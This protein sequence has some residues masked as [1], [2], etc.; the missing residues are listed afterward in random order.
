MRGGTEYT[1]NSFWI[2]NPRVKTWYRK[3]E[4]GLQAAE[5][6]A[7]MASLQSSY[8]YPAQTLYQ[9]WILMLLNMDR[10]TLWGSAGGMVFENDKSWDARDRM[11]S[12]ESVNKQVH[13]GALSALIPEGEGAALFNPLNWERHDP[14]IL[15]LPAGKSLAGVVCQ[16]VPNGPT[17][18]CTVRC[19]AVCRP[20][21]PSL[22][23]IGMAV[24]AE[25]PEASKRVELLQ[26][27]E[28]RYY[29]ARI[30]P[31]T[32]ALASLRLKPSGRE[33]LGGPANVLVAEKPKSQQGDPGDSMLARS[34]RV[35]LASSSD[36]KPE[37]TVADG[38]LF[39]LVEIKSK[40]FGGGPSRRVIQFY[41]DY[42][43]IDFETELNNIPDRTVIVSEFPLAGDVEEVRRAIPNGFS[44]GAWAKPN[45]ALPGWTKG[46]V[47]AV[48]WI[49]YTLAGG[50]GVAILDRGLSGR[51]LNGR[52]PIIYL[53]NAT[54]KYYGWPNPWLTGRGKHVLAYA[55]VAH[56]GNW[57][58]ARIPHMAWEYNNPAI[59]V[60]GRKVVPEKSFV[61]TSDNLVVQVIRREGVEIEMR[62]IECLGYP[63]TAEIAVN[64]PHHG[65]AL[66]DLRGRNP[67][68]LE[69]GPVYRFPVRPQQIV[70]V[71]F[72][73]HSAVEEIKPI[74]K[75]DD[76]VPKS[77]LAALHQYGNYKGHPPRGDNVPIS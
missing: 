40:F 10:N 73:A 12:V 65:A 42:P 19:R 2:E 69:G 26:S 4:Q 30:D 5:S 24:A 29:S 11:V 64:F 45:P 18:P 67:Q 39:T 33:V 32:G 53:L 72:Q 37:I 17:V 57:D 54:D 27:I 55:L 6:I 1:F 77:K 41:K 70:T 46:I 63:G 62:L 61:Q 48:G 75:W 59:T 51:E 58:Q 76:L 71:R 31:N 16:A 14:V 3:N 60:S 8:P 21:L 50:G 20:R 52:T 47:P 23:V 9:A 15:D 49:H 38:P 13:T 44:H 22:G 34:D 66:T 7:T 35:R 68:A 28:T 25:G 43:R 74:L 56:E 36:S